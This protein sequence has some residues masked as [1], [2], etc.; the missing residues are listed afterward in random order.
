MALFRL[1]TIS[2]KRINERSSNGA[3]I[4]QTRRITAPNQVPQKNL[5]SSIQTKNEFDNNNPYIPSN[6]FLRHT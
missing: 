1:Q 4:E 5:H 6:Q 3:P 2:K